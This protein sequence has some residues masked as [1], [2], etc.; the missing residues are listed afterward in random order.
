MRY[1]KFVDQPTL[2]A[3]AT[4]AGVH[5]P[6]SKS[7]E[8]CEADRAP[9]FSGFSN[10]SGDEPTD[11]NFGEDAPSPD[12]SSEDTAPHFEIDTATPAKA[13]KAAKVIEAAFQQLSAS[14]PAHVDAADW[15]QAVEDGRVFLTQ[16]G[17]QAETLGWS[18]DDLFGL[19]PV[20]DNPHHSY[21]RLSRHDLTGLIWLLRGRPV[22]AMTETSAAV[23]GAGGGVTTYRKQASARS[24]RR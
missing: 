21:R 3:L 15:Q 5:P 16:W 9:N 13:A 7:E 11:S 14:C 24:G 20:P 6:I 18:A 2:A 1:R 23:Q 17:E 10:F 12:S 8:R 19:A 22:V 4:L